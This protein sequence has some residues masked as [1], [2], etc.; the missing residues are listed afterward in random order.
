MTNLHVT[1][2]DL[3]VKA[4]ESMQII[5]DFVQGLIDKGFAYPAETGDVYFD[6]NLDKEQRMGRVGK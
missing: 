5:I 4:S 3:N 6:Y 2:A 1:D